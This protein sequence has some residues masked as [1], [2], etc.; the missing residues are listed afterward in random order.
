M[1]AWRLSHGGISA[2]TSATAPVVACDVLVVGAG[3]GG[4][5][6]AIT[7]HL[8][9]LRVIVVEK[10]SQF[11]GTT[12]LSGGWI[13]VPCSHHARAA[14]V[15]DSLAAARQ[16]L[17]HEL[18]E[19]FDAGRVDT[20]LNNAA[21]MV[22]FFERSTEV[23]FQLGREYPDYHPTQP[24]GTTGGRAL[25]PV[26]F[27]GRE[28]G[29]RLAWLRPPVREM[30]L[31]GL[32]VGSGPDFHHFFNARRSPRSAWYVARRIARHIGDVARH[33][34]D[35]LLMS[36]N[37]LMARLGKSVFAL[38]IPLWLATPAHD[39]LTDGSKVVGAR[40]MREGRLIEVRAARGVVLAAG[41]FARDPV[42]RRALYPHAPGADEHY[43]LTAPGNTGDGL[44][45]AE[46]VGAAIES[47]C[48]SAAPWMP[49]SRVPYAD[50][51]FGVYP[52]S[53]ERG[54]PGGILVGP[55]GR[56]FCNESD[57]YHDVVRAMIA[58]RKPGHAPHAF[59]VADTRF[60]RRYGLGMAKPFPLPLRTYLRSGY[61]R[62]ARTLEGLALAIGVDASALIATIDTFNRNAIRGNDPEFHRGDNAYNRYQGDLA[63]QP[64]PCLAPIEKPP[65]Y[66]VRIVPGDL[67]TFM[68][69]RTDEVGNVLD[70]R[71]R[72]VGGLF[73]VGNDMASPFGGHYPGP[74]SN[75]GPAMTFGYVCGRHL[76]ATATR[77]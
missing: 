50:G 44:R 47:S 41:G 73:A 64:N 24:G 75:I 38:D 74:G 55:D 70:A 51:T 25:F 3:A 27:D 56:R 48:A 30:T 17:E 32:K 15:D 18:G 59:L 53:Y 34:R 13:W 72:P 14:G 58:Q 6:T 52:H 61:L 57:S 22:D 11:G 40:V 5:A 42:R 35:V 36:G 7:A 45:M 65:F 31:F 33:G 28:L 71:S 60:L 19:R 43:S 23:R 66:A 39:L 68:G 29:D 37:A 76:A 62:R 26:P 12:A 49:V 46:A 77:P 1:A 69:L 16:Y 2:V 63:Q 54:K 8:A 21:R 4:L 20:Y 10:E 67:G 9:G